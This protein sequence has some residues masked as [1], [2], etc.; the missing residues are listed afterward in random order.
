MM[1]AS[2]FRLSPILLLAA[3]LVALAV[4]FAPGGQPAQAQT[5]TVWSATLTVAQDPNSGLKGCTGTQQ[6]LCNSQLTDDDFTYGGVDY[7]FTTIYVSGGGSLNLRLNK[8]I[9]PALKS[10]VTLH[11]GSSQFPL[12]DGNRTQGIQWDPDT[13]GCNV[14]QHRP[15][16]VRR[17][18]GL[19]EPDGVLH[20]LPRLAPTA[21]TL[22]PGTTEYWSETLAVNGRGLWIRLWVQDR[23]AAVRALRSRTTTSVYHGVQH[24]CRVGARRL[25]RYPPAHP[26]QGAQGQ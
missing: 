15:E 13:L 22:P 16:L 25:R 26:G 7:T 1:R 20:D 17:R 5:T 21:P 12:A 4:L 8:A 11:V 19:A 18:H 3:A 24:T 2:V 23:T 14:G 6:S 9:P 10:A